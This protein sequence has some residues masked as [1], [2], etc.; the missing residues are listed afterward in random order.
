MR[1]LFLIL[2]FS[3]QL[4]G[5]TVPSTANV[6]GSSSWI[7]RNPLPTGANL[8]DVAFG[9]GTFVAVG[10]GGT[11]V[12]SSD[13][14]ITWTTV[15]S[16]TT[17]F[18][19]A[20]TFKENTFIGLTYFGSIIHSVDGAVWSAGGAIPQ[21]TGIN[22][23]AHNGEVVVVVGSSSDH[24]IWISPDLVA[25]ESPPSGVSENSFR[26]LKSVA[27]G[28]GRFVAVGWQGVIVVSDDGAH[29]DPVESG[30]EEELNRVIYGQG[31]FVAGGE[32][33]TILT[34]LDGLTW[35]RRD[36]GS[37]ASI[38]DISFGNGSWIALGS[39]GAA[40]TSADGSTWTRNAQLPGDPTG[41]AYGNGAFVAVGG[42]GLILRSSGDNPWTN[43]RKGSAETF[44]DVSY[45]NGIFVAVG[46]SNI[47][48]SV[49]GA[50][51]IETSQPGRPLSRVIYANG[52]FVAVGARGQILTS[53][54]TN[55]IKRASGTTRHLYGVHYR[56]DLFVVVG[57]KG[58]ILTSS[59]AITWKK[60]DSLTERNLF[61]VAYGNGKFL[62]VGGGYFDGRTPS[63][64]LRSSVNG[65]EWKPAGGSIGGV[66]TDIIFARNRFYAIVNGTPS[67]A[68]AGFYYLKRSDNGLNWT[69]VLSGSDLDGYPTFS[70][71]RYLA[72]TFF[73]TTF[74]GQVIS[75]RGTFAS[76]ATLG[77]IPESIHSI[78]YGRNSLVIVGD[79]GLIAQSPLPALDLVVNR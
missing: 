34:S 70:S 79:R 5:E 74:Q 51:W 13:D 45:G 6:I 27:Y 52:R 41:L 3:I 46:T 69:T 53:K 20:V 77:D 54:G 75:S 7:R 39:S 21:T 22:D 18:L 8:N 19:I 1:V 29:W 47:V 73:V 2:L 9:N 32:N 14:G 59:D 31:L 76:T 43:Q 65:R 67:G 42:V 4:H 78:A 35:T 62:A 15:P 12:T 24:P 37:D 33:G 38:Q 17:E 40:L 64:V 23:I 58:M 30:V 57:E 26:G 66:V 48:R 10:D 71:V 68:A 36:S 25:W 72:D 55:W 28:S 44:V 61:A 49:D 60:R 63:P 56:N 16:P 11:I 50:D